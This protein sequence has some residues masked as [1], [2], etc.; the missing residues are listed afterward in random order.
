MA[1]TTAYRLNIRTGSAD[2]DGLLILIGGELVAILVRLADDGHG[3]DVGQWF[4]EATFGEWPVGRK[5]SFPDVQA[6]ADWVCSG[7]GGE[8]YEIAAGPV[9]LA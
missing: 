1:P 8:R 4:V 2:E 3:D 5:R 9:R 6:A 7:A